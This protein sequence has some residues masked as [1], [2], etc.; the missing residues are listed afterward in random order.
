MDGFIGVV[1]AISVI[2]SIITKLASNDKKNKQKQT[3]TSSSENRSGGIDLAS[4]IK[5]PKEKPTE[6]FRASVERIRI[7][8]DNK[9]KQEQ[10]Q[11]SQ[12]SQ[13]IKIVK[14]KNN[15]NKKQKEILQKDKSRKKV[16]SG[17]IISVPISKNMNVEMAKIIVLGEAINNPR[18]K[19]SYN[20]K[21]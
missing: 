12:S 17:N 4:E 6:D 1:I 5:N 14:T 2:V 15:I 18:F 19:N 8:K 3:N 21:W 9:R 10:I 7:E 13:K 16:T 11:S 20:K